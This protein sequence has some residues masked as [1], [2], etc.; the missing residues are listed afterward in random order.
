M[1]GLRNRG[2]RSWQGRDD[3]GN[4]NDGDDDGDDGDGW[5]TYCK[6]NMVGAYCSRNTVNFNSRRTRHVF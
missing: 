3:D 2:M 4:G 5:Y 6:Q 1:N